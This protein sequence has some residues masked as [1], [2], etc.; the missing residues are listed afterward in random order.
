[1]YSIKG[2]KAWNKTLVYKIFKLLSIYILGRYVAV[3]NSFNS[4][5]PIA[6]YLTPRTSRE[7]EG[8]RFP[9]KL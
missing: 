7:V 1:M 3:L 5:N 4:E 8:A 2:H 9:T 6:E